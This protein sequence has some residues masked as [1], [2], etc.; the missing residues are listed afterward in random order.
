MFFS[1]IL[2]VGP[3]KAYRR[4]AVPKKAKSVLWQKGNTNKE[5]TVFMVETKPGRKYPY[6]QV[7]KE[8]LGE[9]IL[10]LKAIK[11]LKANAEKLE[12][13][14]A[15]INNEEYLAI[16]MS[17]EAKKVKGG[18]IWAPEKEIKKIHEAF[19]EF[20]FIDM[21]LYKHGEKESV[22]IRGFTVNDDVKPEVL[23]C[24]FCKQENEFWFPYANAVLK[25]ECGALVT[26]SPKGEEAEAATEISGEEE[27]EFKAVDIGNGWNAVFIKR[28]S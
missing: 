23:K 11:P 2:A 26:L 20:V 16:P 3:D 28:K 10:W 5:Y 9:S 27:P 22:K 24:P 6:V 7:P 13:W 17:D 8:F 18:L 19:G 15:I 4:A 25:C 12:A 21:T 1:K 14:T